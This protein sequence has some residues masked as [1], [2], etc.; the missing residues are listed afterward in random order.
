MVETFKG[1]PYARIDEMVAGS[2]DTQ[3]D[4]PSPS[5]RGVNIARR[6]REVQ[7][8][9]TGQELV[10]AFKAAVNGRDRLPV[11]GQAS[12]LAA[13][14]ADIMQNGTARVNGNGKA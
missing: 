10:R 6:L 12:A 7:E 11:I 9:P 4:N 5:V 14:R 2:A 13:Q 3:I 1:E 8:Y